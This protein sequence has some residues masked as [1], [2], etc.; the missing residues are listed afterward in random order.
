MHIKDMP[1]KTWN[2]PVMG[3]EVCMQVYEWIDKRRGPAHMPE[4][5]DFNLRALG[6]SCCET[7]FS[8]VQFNNVDKEE[9]ARNANQGTREKANNLMPIC[10]TRI[11]AR[12]ED[13]F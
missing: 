4:D 8:H 6:S 5:V 3:A 1:F 10:S 7:R 13:H 2:H 9:Y 12:K 11:P